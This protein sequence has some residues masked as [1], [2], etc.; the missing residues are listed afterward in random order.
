MST[1]DEDKPP[2]VGAAEDALPKDSREV[3]VGKKPANMNISGQT[4]DLKSTETSQ[5]GSRE[6]NTTNALV[7]KLLR[8]TRMLLS[9]RSFFYSYD[10][11]I[12][13]RLGGEIVKNPELPLSKSVDPL[14]SSSRFFGDLAGAFSLMTIPSSFGITI[15][16]CLSPK[17]DITRSSCL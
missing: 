15:W 13:R 10:L 8:T 12:T 3:A 9:S 11:D 5:L 1:A 4:S 7:P 6:A 16:H 2:S 17:T 14:V